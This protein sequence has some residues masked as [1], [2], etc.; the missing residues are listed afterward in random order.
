MPKAFRVDN[1][2]AATLFV[3]V[4]LARQRNAR[5]VDDKALISSNRIAFASFSDD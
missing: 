5:R 1:R 3:D 4:N 2:D